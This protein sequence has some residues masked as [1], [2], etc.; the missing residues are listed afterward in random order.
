MFASP[1]QWLA[2]VFFLQVGPSSGA[3]QIEVYFSPRGGCQAAIIR[4]VGRA[5][6]SI[7]VQ[8]YS[9]TCQK[10]AKALLDA[11]GRGVDVEAIVDKSNVTSR[12]SAAKYLKYSGVPVLIDAEHAIAH[13][14][15]IIIDERTVITG[16]FNFSTS[17]EE[18]NAE[19]LLV[20]RGPPSLAQQYLANY[21]AHRTH[22]TPFESA[23]ADSDAAASQPT[24]PRRRATRYERIAE[25]TDGKTVFITPSGKRYHVEG[26]RYAKNG[27]QVGLEDAKKYGYTP[28]HACRPFR[29]LKDREPDRRSKKR[30]ARSGSGDS[31]GTVYVTKTGKKYHRKG[32]SS[33][34]RSRRAIKLS[35]A[36]EQ[37]YAPCS[38]CRP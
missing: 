34:S 24:K 21:Q 18:R 30:R 9:F 36:K 15:I 2:V 38:R 3:P 17:A 4:E 12:Y 11:K 13:N 20:I 32:C 5:E 22:S 33:L 23:I 1:L 35:E 19:N 10:I 28:C 6:K 31:G 25:A 27:K 8:A 7:R 29:D 37:G 14:K 26:C 16:S